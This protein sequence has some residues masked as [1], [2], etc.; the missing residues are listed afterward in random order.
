MESRG[1][2]GRLSGLEFDGSV[3][4]FAAVADLHHEY[5]AARVIQ[6]A[7]H[8]PVPD[9][10]TPCS[11]VALASHEGLA[12]SPWVVRDTGFEKTEDARS[13]RTVQLIERLDCGLG[14]LNR[15][16]HTAA[17]TRRA[18]RSCRDGDE[19]RG[20]PDS[21]ARTG[22]VQAAPQA[23]WPRGSCACDAQAAPRPWTAPRQAERSGCHPCAKYSIRGKFFRLSNGGGGCLR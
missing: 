18:I 21:L 12:D 4:N 14:K 6:V 13:D 20:Q 9:P 8:A 10:V 16:N 3:V 22:P 17:S 2:G 1:G 15:P 7:N 5:N 19:R 23:Q 11:R